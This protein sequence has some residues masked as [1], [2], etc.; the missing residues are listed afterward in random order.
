MALRSSWLARRLFEGAR[1]SV[2]RLGELAAEALVASASATSA[3]TTAPAKTSASSRPPTT[4]TA[5]ASEVAARSAAAIVEAA[6]VGGSRRAGGRR[7]RR[8]HWAGRDGIHHGVA[9]LDRRRFV[10][11]ARI[12]G[13]GSGVGEFD[14]G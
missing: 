8:I 14:E 4:T 5:A 11:R 3:A 1:R 13:G 12:I 2:F 9:R 10:F 7:I 6:A